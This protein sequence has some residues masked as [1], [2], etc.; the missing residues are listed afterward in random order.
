MLVGPGVLPYDDKVT[1]CQLSHENCPHGDMVLQ[2]GDSFKRGREASGNSIISITERGGY[3][4]E[5]DNFINGE[6]RHGVT[7]LQNLLFG[8][9]WFIL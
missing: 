4:F 8:L 5:S 1:A 3:L 6:T 2:L 9:S 7:F